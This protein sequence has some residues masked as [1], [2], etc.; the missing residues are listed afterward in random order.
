MPERKLAALITALHRA[1]QNDRPIT[2]VGAGLPQLT[3]QMGR[4]KSYAER[5]F[6]FVSIGRLDEAAAT[7]AVAHPIE[8]EECGIEQEAV[9]RILQ[10]TRGYPYFLQEW[11]KQSWDAAEQCPIAAADVELAHPAALAALDDSFF[12]VRF[13]RTTPSEKRYLRAMAELGEGPCSSTAIADLL[14]RKASSLGPVRASLIAQGMIYTPGYG[15][16]AFTVPLF[17]EFMRLAI[18]VD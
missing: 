4:A 6:R 5:L 11:G 8:A 3:G 13:D 17:D 2:L 16:T 1:R 15:E 18:P 7:A 12:R 14:G 10:V 9:D